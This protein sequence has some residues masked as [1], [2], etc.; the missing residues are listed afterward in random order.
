MER[1]Q[2]RQCTVREVATALLAACAVVLLL[3]AGGLR[4]WAA[5]LELGPERQVA[6]ALT[7]PAAR[8]QAA[9]GPNLPKDAA[10]RW[11]RAAARSEGADG[12]GT[13]ALESA[14]ISTLVEEA[15]PDP[16]PAT[17]W[18]GPPLPPQPKRVLLIGDSLM[19][20][21][22]GTAL[23]RLIASHAGMEV[24]RHAVVSSG[25]TR[26]DYFDWFAL[27]GRLLDE[28]RYDAVV[29]VLG[30]N[31][32][33]AI[34]GDGRVYRHG[35]E[36]WDE[37]YAHRARSFVALL[38][39]KAGRAYWLG[40]P[41]MRD[42]RFHAATRRVNAMFEEGC[43]LRPNAEYVDLAAWIGGE[44]G[45]YTTY[46][47]VDGKRRQVRA[48]DGIHFTT[49]GGEVLADHLYAMLVADLAPPRGND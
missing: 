7:E 46:L 14:T 12:W 16:A 39:A 11:F 26:P 17:E 4:D 22:M 24:T 41:P 45:E 1:S 33:Q 2:A 10:R 8:A 29:C 23:E 36:E 9:V 43:R 25:I 48:S 32:I 38:A 3:D 49:A 28:Q 44:Q 31:D 19:G 42:D 18:V 21:G 6:L 34:S 15:R 30:G 27:A 13:S 47:T 37:A 40:L 35:T 20:W 5:G